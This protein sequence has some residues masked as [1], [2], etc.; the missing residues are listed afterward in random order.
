LKRFFSFQLLI[1][2]SLLTLVLSAPIGVH[3]GVVHATKQ[4]MSNFSFAAAGDWGC[5]SKAQATVRNMQ[6]TSPELVLALGDLSYQKSA[7]CWFQIMSPLINKTKIVFGDHEYN[8]KNSSRLKEYQQEFD[9][10]KQYYSFDNGNVHF[11]AMSS[12]MPFDKASEQYEFLKQDLESASQNKSVDWIVVYIYEMMY[13]SPTLHKVTENLRDT[14]HLL[15]DRYG[16]DL[17]LQAHS[18]NYQR[19]YPITYN[20]ADPSQPIITNKDVENYSDPKGSIFVVAGTG[21]A[22]QHDFTG[23]APYIVKQ[24]NRFGFLDVDIV[25]NGTK[26]IAKFYENREGTAKD[27]FVIS[28]SHK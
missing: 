10:D 7:D 28:N 18:H 20:V 22:D 1:K 19:S 16:V 9:L 27:Y 13:S 8:F 3:Y 21:G 11:V 26:M 14:Y 24:F 6:N 12:E 15:F 5:D 25:D 4:N 23:Q 2:I 17:V